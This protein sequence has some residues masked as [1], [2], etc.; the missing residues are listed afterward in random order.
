M[1]DLNFLFAGKQATNF[2]FITEA[3][4]VFSWSESEDKWLENE[5]KILVWEH[6]Q[7]WFGFSVMCIIQ[8]NV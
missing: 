7:S 5:K 1:F 4:I 6:I 2:K 3:S 8:Q